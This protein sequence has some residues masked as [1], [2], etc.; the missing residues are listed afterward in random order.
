MILS[1]DRHW[2]NENDAW[3]WWAISYMEF[4]YDLQITTA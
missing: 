2:Y 4:D 1:I 3:L